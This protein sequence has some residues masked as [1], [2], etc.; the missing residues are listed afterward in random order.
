M[1]VRAN[2]SQMKIETLMPLGKLDPALESSF[3]TLATPRFCEASSAML[4]LT[5]LAQFD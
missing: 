3:I 1:T 5:Q 4:E 2:F